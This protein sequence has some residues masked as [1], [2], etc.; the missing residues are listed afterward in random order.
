MRREGQ[1]RLRRILRYPFGSVFF[2][3]LILSVPV[4]YVHRSTVFAP[5]TDLPAVAVV[6]TGQFDRVHAG[7]DLLEAEEVQSLFIS[8]V[9]PRAG[10]TVQGFAEQFELTPTQLE[11]LESGA[12]VLATVAD[13]TIENAVETA[14]WLRAN[15][16]IR[17]VALVTSHWHMARASRALDRATFGVRIVRVAA[18]P[19][20]GRLRLDTEEFRKFIVTWFVTLLP[21][22]LWPADEAA[23][24]APYESR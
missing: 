6:F 19:P 22:S 23:L 7:L 1:S 11:A 3:L 8:G 15:P 4:D 16:E 24:C 21:R 5:V 20:D 12:I 17:Q 10:I 2:A 13:N 14:C 9:N 18:S